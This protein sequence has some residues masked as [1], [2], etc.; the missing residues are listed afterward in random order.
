MVF[1][2]IDWGKIFS[3]PFWLN[4]NPGELSVR[5][6][7]IFL[8]VLFVCYV[9]Y[10]ASKLADRSFV[11]KR[12]FILAKFVEKTASF[13]LFMAVCFTFI[14]FFRYEAIPLLGGRFW[15]LIWAITGLVWA[16][17]L[18]KYYLRVIPEQREKLEAKQQKDKYLVNV[19]KKK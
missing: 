15:I 14:F 17:Y 16:I 6:E 7:R 12:N 11:S 8:V 2:G 3:V 9:L 10:L 4:V 19:K 1:L 13:F 18:L 5:F